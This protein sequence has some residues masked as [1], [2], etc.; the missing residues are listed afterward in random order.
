MKNTPIQK[1]IEY[2]VTNGRGYDRYKSN[3]L[4]DEEKN[5]EIGLQ[6]TLARMDVMDSKLNEKDIIL[7]EKQLEKLIDT[8]ETLGL[9]LSDIKTADQFDS[10]LNYFNKESLIN[11][12]RPLRWNE[13]IK[14]LNQPYK[15][16]S[17]LKE[18]QLDYLGAN[19]PFDMQLNVKKN[20][21]E[22]PIDSPFLID[23]GKYEDEL[24]DSD[25]ELMSLDEFDE[26]FDDYLDRLIREGHIGP[27]SKD[28]F[29]RLKEEYDNDSPKNNQA[30]DYYKF[31]DDFFDDKKDSEDESD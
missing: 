6:I 2:I 30:D 27:S 8:Y 11:K 9:K 22:K 15:N 25:I 5:T 28:E 12:V 10:A 1:H 20:P 4:I 31:F 16:H 14:H 29:R 26:N 18:L 7:F 21:T 17:I 23:M 19:V 13:P 3:Y 24:R